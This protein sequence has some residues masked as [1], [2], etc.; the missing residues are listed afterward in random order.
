MNKE[1]Q[2][3]SQSQLTQQ[4]LVLYSFRVNTQEFPLNLEIIGMI[5]LKDENLDYWVQPIFSDTQPEDDA[6]ITEQAINLTRDYNNNKAKLA[7]LREKAIKF[8][9]NEGHLTY[10]YNFFAN[11]ICLYYDT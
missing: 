8:Y 4:F 2:N 7:D 5:P 11:Q 6:F 9:E 1:D 10:D 3:V